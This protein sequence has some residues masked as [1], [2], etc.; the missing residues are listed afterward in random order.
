MSGN[1]K[2]QHFKVSALDQ[3]AN[4]KIYW[5]KFRPHIQLMQEARHII[6]CVLATPSDDHLRLIADKCAKKL[7]AELGEECP[8]LSS[9][10]LWLHVVRAF[11]ESTKRENV[12]EQR[13]REAMVRLLKQELPF[14]FDQKSLFV[15]SVDNE[16]DRDNEQF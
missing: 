8:N 16:I 10:R 11:H 7:E 4:S 14:Q 12:F 2:P 13:F 1:K 6:S 15:D 3:E 9:C 5:Q